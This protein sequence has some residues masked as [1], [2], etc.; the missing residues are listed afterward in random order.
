MQKSEIGHTKEF[1]TDIAN[2][3]SPISGC[4]CFNTL[5]I[6]ELNDTLRLVLMLLFGLFSKRFSSAMFGVSLVLFEILRDSQKA[7]FILHRVTSDTFLDY[8]PKDIFSIIT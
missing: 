6:Y 8:Q 2:F 7:F 4:T 5:K 1:M 3:E